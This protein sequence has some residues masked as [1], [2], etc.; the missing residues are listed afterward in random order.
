MVL[1]LPNFFLLGRGGLVFE[2]EG[3]G[4]LIGSL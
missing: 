4:A 2:W 1:L 3:A